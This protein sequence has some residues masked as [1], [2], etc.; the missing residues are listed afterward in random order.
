MFYIFI[1][2]FFISVDSDIVSLIPKEE[3]ENEKIESFEIPG[4]DINENEIYNKKGKGEVEKEE[5]EEEDEEE[6]DEDYDDDENNENK[7]NLNSFSKQP[8][9]VFSPGISVKIVDQQKINLKSRMKNNNFTVFD[10]EKY[11]KIILQERKEIETAELK[12]LE[13]EILEL[14]KELNEDEVVKKVVEEVVNVVELNIPLNGTAVLE[15]SIRVPKNSSTLY[16]ERKVEIDVENSRRKEERELVQDILLFSVLNGDLNL[17]MIID[18]KLMNNAD[19]YNNNN[20]NSNNNNNNN[21]NNYNVNIVSFSVKDYFTE[22]KSKETGIQIKNEK[23]KNKKNSDDDDV[24]DNAILI[25]KSKKELPPLLETNNVKENE[26]E[27]SADFNYFL[28]PDNELAKI[29][30]EA[31]EVKKNLLNI[32]DIFFPEIF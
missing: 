2:F 23:K 26:N 6:E 17:E 7:F 24:L 27:K 1:Y 22:I 19:S 10:A 21:K 14:D 8:S 13:L 31:F 3:F 12:K 16:N 18:K 25:L 4:G 30:V 29:L 15:N 20:N 32:I 5:D 28:S 11:A 9:V